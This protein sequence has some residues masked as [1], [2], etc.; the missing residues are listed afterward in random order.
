MSDVRGAAI[1]VLDSVVDAATGRAGA[2][3]SFVLLV[4][5]SF[6]LAARVFSGHRYLAL[7]L[8]IAGLVTALTAL[9]LC[10][11]SQGWLGR[12]DTTT[13]CWLVAHRSLGLDVAATVLT[14]F[15]SPAATAAAGVLCAAMLSWLARS[16]VPGIVIIGTL[17]AAAVACTALKV[18]VARPRPPLQWQA[19]LETDPSFPSSHVTGTAALLG[20]IA[21]VVGMDQRRATRIGLTVAVIIAVVLVAATRLYLGLHWLT[22]VTAGA[23]LAAV[24]VTIGAAVLDAQRHRPDDPT[25]QAGGQSQTPGGRTS[26]AAATGGP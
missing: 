15:G 13:T 12:V 25:A 20:I 17:G 3:T 7:G 1:D 11:N 21:V 8:R 5:A 22:D 19:V 9:T 6:L 2:P 16:V 26:A 10:I 24:F 4:V 14:D 18:V 23:I